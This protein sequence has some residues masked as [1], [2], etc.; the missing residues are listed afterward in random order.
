MEI[1][2][3][4]VKAAGFW[5]I[6]VKQIRRDIHI[7]G[8][9]ER[10]EI[11]F[12][13]E[14]YEDRLYI[15]ES[16]FDEDI[17]HKLKIIYTLEY[18]FNQGLTKIEPYIC[19]EKNEYITS[20]DSRFWQLM[21]YV[22]GV[23]LNRP[24]YVFEKWRGRPLAEFLINLREKSPEVPYSDGTKPFSIKDYIYALVHQVQQY[25]PDLI[26]KIKPVIRF[27]ENGFMDVHDR[28]P[29]GFC[30]GDYH[31]L[32]IIWTSN[33]IHT[34]IDWEFL[35]YKPEMYD[36]ANLI[37]CIGVEDPESLPG[38]LI[39][40]FIIGLQGAGLFSAMSWCYLIELIIAIR[41][42]WLSEW[43]RHEDHEMIMLETVYMTLLMNNSNNLKKIWG[44]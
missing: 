8:S 6:K 17:D 39:R 31:G 26:D 29:T 41:F 23:A 13:V 44:V 30:H 12:V 1:N 28:L 35:G 5:N 2:N 34:V 11:R 42:A 38:E 15:L 43:L 22:N 10:C 24:E 4:V 20:C 19:T 25:K 33:G 40:E 16:I 9:P 37:G 3:A 14:D 7:A 21:P 27:L 18:L 32:N 36:A